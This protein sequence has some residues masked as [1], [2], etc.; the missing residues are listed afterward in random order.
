MSFNTYTDIQSIQV[1]KKSKTI[2][3]DGFLSNII[4][5]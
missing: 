4:I 5:F 3:F 1:R 2:R